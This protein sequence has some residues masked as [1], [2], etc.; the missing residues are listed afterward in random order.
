MAKRELFER[1]KIEPEGCRGWLYEDKPITEQDIVMP[2][3]EKLKTRLAEM[4]R[5]VDRDTMVGL[6]M[7]INEINL[8]SDE[9]QKEETNA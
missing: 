7:A 3:L 1:I 9:F 2:F 4:A 5:E 8:L 6:I